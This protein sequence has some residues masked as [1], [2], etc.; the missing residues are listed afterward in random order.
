[1]AKKDPEAI[2][3]LAELGS[4]EALF[5]L[6]L[7]YYNGHGVQQDKAKDEAAGQEI[8]RRHSRG[9]SS[10]FSLSELSLGGDGS[11]RFWNDVAADA[12]C[13]NVSSPVRSDVSCF[14]VFTRTLY[15]SNS[16]QKGPGVLYDIF[17]VS[18]WMASVS[19]RVDGSI[20]QRRDSRSCRAA[21]TDARGAGPG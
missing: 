6:G 8:G 12:E 21:G 11:A 16:S 10:R 2:T 17:R 13:A 20:R 19:P 9:L 3:F 5:S 14:V 4:I 1:M 18:D 15:H 7:A